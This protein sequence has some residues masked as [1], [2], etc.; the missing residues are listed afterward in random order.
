MLYLNE[1]SIK[2]A[3][4]MSEVTDSIDLAYQ[5]YEAKQYHMPTRMRVPHGANDFL[6][7]PCVTREVIGTKLVAVHPKNVHTPAIQGLVTL[8][9]ATT[10]TPIA[11][12]NGT[13][14]TGLRT[15][16]IGAS[17]V[18][19]LSSP[20]VANLALIG[21]GTQGFYQALAACAERDIKHIH[22]FNRSKARMIDFVDQ[23]Q[24]ELGEHIKISIHHSAADAVEKSEVVITATTSSHPVLPDDEALLKGKLLIG[25]GSFRPDMREFPHAVYR[26]IDNVYVDSTDAI[27]ES[28][29]IVQPIE[30]K[31]LHPSQVIPFSKVVTG[32]QSINREQTILFKS[33]GMGLFDALS[34][35]HIY[36]KAQQKNLGTS[37]TL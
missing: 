17:A 18:R 20:D 11:M 15:G 32:V 31:W 25:I 13:V 3:V 5:T 6:L 19:H 34:A 36:Q 23:L 21:T 33:T 12:L 7:M 35:Y 29:D 28:G 30:Q 2:Q 22:L 27:Q 24:K 8:N 37:L 9:D 1:Q 4:S 10:G 26:L 16:A 14:L